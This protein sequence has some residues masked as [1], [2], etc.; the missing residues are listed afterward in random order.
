MQGAYGS[1]FVEDDI[2]AQPVELVAHATALTVSGT[3]DGIPGYAGFRPILHPGNSVTTVGIREH[4]PWPGR[5]YE[6]Q[7]DWN[8]LTVFEAVDDL[9]GLGESQEMCTWIRS[10]DPAHAAEVVA[11]EYVAGNVP[12]KQTRFRRGDPCRNLHEIGIRMILGEK[13]IPMPRFAG[14]VVEPIRLE[15][16]ATLS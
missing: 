14:A 13:L 15:G 3:L 5:E 12:T 1:V 10:G 7:V 16:V 4:H 6:H 11:V 8:R 9:E 2:A